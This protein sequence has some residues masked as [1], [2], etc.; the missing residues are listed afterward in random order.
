VRAF[1]HLPITASRRIGEREKRASE[2][3]RGDAHE[4]DLHD[5]HERPPMNCRPPSVQK[6]MGSV[7]TRPESA[8]LMENG[9]G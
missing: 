9:Q 1:E 7:M 6:S 5:G 3:R 2:K 4:E 8:E